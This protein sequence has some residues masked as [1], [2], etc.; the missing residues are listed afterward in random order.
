MSTDQT[1]ETASK[2]AK[3]RVFLHPGPVLS[4]EDRDRHF[5]SAGRLAELYGLRLQDCIVVDWDR[6]NKIL[7]HRKQESD[8][9]LYP[10]RDGIYRLPDKLNQLRSN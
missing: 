3:I 5:I 8:V 4:K 10:R 2:V 6:P 9:H 1:P 7:G